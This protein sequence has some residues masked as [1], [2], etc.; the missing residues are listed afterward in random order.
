MKHKIRIF[1]SHDELVCKVRPVEIHRNS[2]GQFTWPY[3]NF[4]VLAGTDEK[5][6]WRNEAHGYMIMGED[7]RPVVTK[8]FLTPRTLTVGTLVL[9]NWN[10]HTG[11]RFNYESDS[12]IPPTP[13]PPFP[14]VSNA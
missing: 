13:L 5:N 4:R 3:T 7:G 11:E 14:E 6:P 1:G 12:V 2:A 8:F 9:F 10:S